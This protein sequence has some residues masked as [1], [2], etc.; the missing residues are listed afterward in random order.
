MIT[1]SIGGM[2]VQVEKASD[3]WVNQMIADARKRGVA[4][5]VQVHVDVPGA[6][7]RLTTPGCS[8][9]G[10]GRQPNTTERRIIDAW[11]H[12]GLGSG[13]FTPGDLRAFLNELAR[14]I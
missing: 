12:R 6:N 10:G 7:V 14:L 8:G 11:N 2:R 3:G 9:S 13:Q 1:V 5:C 4:L